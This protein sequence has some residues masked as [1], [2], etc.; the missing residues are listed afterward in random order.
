MLSSSLHR[1]KGEEEKR[2]DDSSLL[3]R[4]VVVLWRAVLSEGCKSVTAGKVICLD[5]VQADQPDLWTVLEC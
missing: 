4:V 1:F 3:C 5:L 2:R